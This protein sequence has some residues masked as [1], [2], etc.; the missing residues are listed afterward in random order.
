MM[1]DEVQAEKQ[2]QAE[3][4]SGLNFVTALIDTYRRS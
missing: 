3:T 2:I 4:R 1:F